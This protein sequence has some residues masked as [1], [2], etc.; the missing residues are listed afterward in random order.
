M[1]K[2]VINFF[3]EITTIQHISSPIFELVQLQDPSPF[4]FLEKSSI[5]N[6]T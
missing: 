4:S 3:I 1:K 6:G 5:L 2:D